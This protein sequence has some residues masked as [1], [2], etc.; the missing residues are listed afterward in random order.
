M[1]TSKSTWRCAC[2]Y[3]VALFW[4]KFYAFTRQNPGKDHLNSRRSVYLLKN[5]HSVFLLA[6]LLLPPPKQAEIH[7]SIKLATV[8]VL[9]FLR[10]FDAYPD[11]II[12]V[13]DP[14]GVATVSVL[15]D[16][17]LH[18]STVTAATCQEPNSSK[19]PPCILI[20]SCTSR[21]IGSKVA[22]LLGSAG[23]GMR[24]AFQE[25]DEPPPEM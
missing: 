20:G 16:G 7:L 2:P 15:P 11:D 4:V 13:E 24:G 10:S 3:P 19:L 21:L 22:W 14:S 8:S 5:V 23:R 9:R 25:W 17:T 12:S 18:L 1:K 6:R